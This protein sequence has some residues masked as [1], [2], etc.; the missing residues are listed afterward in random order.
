MLSS[1][2]VLTTQLLACAA[3]AAASVGCGAAGTALRGPVQPV[4][5]Q[6]AAESPLAAKCTIEG[7][8]R[9]LAMKVAPYSGVNAQA[10]ASRVLLRFSQQ[11]SAVGVALVI[12]P[13][14][15]DASEG[16]ESDNPRFVDG[17]E[18]GE[19]VAGEATPVLWQTPALDAVEAEHLARGESGELRQ[20]RPS[21][22]RVDSERW[23]S[24]WTAGSIYNGM[25]VHVQTMDRLGVPIGAPITLATDG[26]AFGAPTVAIGA[27]GRGVVAFLQ[28]GDHGF[29]LAA[30]SL[31]C[32]VPAAPEMSAAWAM[33]TP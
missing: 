9:V 16:T 2:H 23:V 15:L 18:L 4:N 5:E 20:S 3:A 32:H 26:F 6:E 11:R 29:E 25:D 12:D 30:V 13:Q 14:S 31:D 21:V 19:P 27:S 24:V 10:D 33:Q 22:A 7:S 1:R 17:S 8:P 28:S